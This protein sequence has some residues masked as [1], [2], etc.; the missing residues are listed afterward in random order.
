MMISI[1]KIDAYALDYVYLNK[2]RY[3]YTVL[4]TDGCNGR[5]RYNGPLCLIV[6]HPQLMSS[7]KQY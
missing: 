5:K 7:F 6:D 2:K 3:K 4:L 1:L